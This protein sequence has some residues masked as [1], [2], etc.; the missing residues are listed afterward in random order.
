[1]GAVPG[2]KLELADVAAKRGQ[3]LAAD[4]VSTP[5][6]EAR[7]HHNGKPHL[8]EWSTGR[9]QPGAGM[10][11]PGAKQEPGGQKLVVGGEQRSCPIERADA[12]GRERAER[13]EPVLDTVQ[14][15]EHVEPA[16]GGVAVAESGHCLIG[17]KEAE[18]ALRAARRRRARGSFRWRAG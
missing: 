8:R 7:L 3:I 13:P 5:T 16:E 17:C 4:D 12:A 9:Q 1:M 11:K 2:T 6:P 15:R 10:R 14:R 18:A